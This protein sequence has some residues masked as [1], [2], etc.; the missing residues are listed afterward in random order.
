MQ[1]PLVCIIWYVH[2]ILWLAAKPHVAITLHFSDKSEGL[3]I[4]WTSPQIAADDSDTW[5]RGFVLVAT[6]IA[7]RRGGIA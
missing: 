3:Y 4:T 7:C 6:R 1:L 2:T 5:Q